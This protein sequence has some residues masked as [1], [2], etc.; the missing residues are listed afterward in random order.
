MKLSVLID[1]IIGKAALPEEVAALDVLGL[2][3]QSGQIKAGDLFIALAGANQH[4][5]RFAA[6]AA[7]N[8]AMA[9]LFDPD[10]GGREMAEAVTKLPVIALENLPVVLGELAARFY[11]WPAKRVGVIGITGTNGKTS[12]S[13]FL[14]QVLD[15]C[16]IIGTLGWGGCG[17]L[18]ATANTTPDAVAVQKILAQM[19]DENQRV[20]AM[21]VSSHGLDQGRVN[22][23]EFAGAVFT[24]LSRDHLDYHQDMQGY[25]A[26]KLKL[27]TWPGLQY[28]VVNLD[29]AYSSKVVR[30][31]PAGVAVWGVSA[32]GKTLASGLGQTVAAENVRHGATGL[33]FTVVWGGQSAD[34]QTQLYGDFNT[35]N[36]LCVLAVA[37]A[38]GMPLDKAVA[39]LQ[40]IKP[41]AGRM[42]SCAKGNP[43]SPHVFIDY[44]HTPDALERVLASVRQHCRGALWVVFGCGGNRDA[45]KRPLMGEV[46]CRLADRVVITD[47]NPRNEDNK[48]IAEAVM[49]GCT[50][51]KAIL[52]QDRQQAIGHAINQAEAGDYVVI[53]GKGHEYYQEIK[54]VRYPFSDKDIAETMLGERFAA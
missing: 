35:G 5:M 13:H 16:G 22:G 20:V 46:A 51:G 40:R 9:I 36:L 19:A 53:A 33:A 49:A 17:R 25:F 21:E 10:R 41:V 50:S 8:G 45:G 52:I 3:L 14:A 44:A 2:C 30:S 23:V 31:I 32:Q 37:L 11:G 28:A 43:D 39:R 1:G 47:D 15:D 38:N 7:E 18:N 6:E 4:G 34:I 54:G 29:D 24:N 48:A 27:F 26:A 42:E 12:C